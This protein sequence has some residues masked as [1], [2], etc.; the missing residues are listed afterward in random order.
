MEKQKPSY[1]VGRNVNWY[2]LYRKQYRD[3]LKKLKI[4]LLYDP[5]IPLLGI[6]LEKTIIP[7]NTCTAIFLAVY[8]K[9]LGYKSNLNVHQQR[10]G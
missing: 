7:K 5:A 6:Y 8:L 1:M 3:S 9:Y 2:S 10:N 4:D